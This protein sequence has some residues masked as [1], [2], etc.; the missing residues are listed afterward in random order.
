MWCD[1]VDSCSCDK[2]TTYHSLNNASFSQIKAGYSSKVEVMFDLIVY[3]QA[4]FNSISRLAACCIKRYSYGERG[5]R[6]QRLRSDGLLNALKPNIKLSLVN[7]S[8]IS[9]S[10][11]CAR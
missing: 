5:I 1:L 8:L 9:I 7:R 11:G 2:P 10:L 3:N 6:F 4:N